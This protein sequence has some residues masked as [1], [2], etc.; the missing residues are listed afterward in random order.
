MASDGSIT[1]CIQLLKAGEEAA[2][3]QLW[4]RYSRRLVG[5]ARTR[6]PR[7]ARRVTDEED[8][9]LSAFDSFYQRAARGRFP[10]LNDRHDLWQ[11]LV[12]IT[13][14]KAID[15]VNHETRP[16]RGSGRVLALADL[17]DRSAEGILSNEPTP[18]LA[19]QLADEVTWLFNRLSNESMRAVAILK[20]EGYTNNEIATKLG[21]VPET[22]ERKLRAIR[23]LWSKD[24]PDESPA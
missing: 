6:L 4:E 7:S 14:R 20:M 10:R 19:A 18:Q 15:A 24:L 16:T 8:V 2:A 9:A 1:E 11:L 3:Q 17:D 5:L 12:V 13:L 23:H 22:V 21:C